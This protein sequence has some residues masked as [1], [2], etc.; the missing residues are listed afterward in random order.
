M[1]YKVIT[2]ILGTVVFGA[3]ADFCGEYDEM[4]S[5]YCNLDRVNYLIDV[6]CY[7]GLA[8]EHIAD[9]NDVEKDALQGALEKIIVAE[10]AKLLSLTQERIL[11]VGHIIA[12]AAI[13]VGAVGCT[14]GIFKSCVQFANSHGASNFENAYEKQTQSA[15]KLAEAVNSRIDCPLVQQVKLEREYDIKRDVFTALKDISHDIS[16]EAWLSGW[17]WLGTAIG[18][19]LTN[20]VGVSV[21]V[22]ANYM[23]WQN[24][25]IKHNLNKFNASLALLNATE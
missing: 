22:Y 6:A 11:K 15:V 1:N 21:E 10:Q 23:L 2:L 14:Y 8:P 24:E 20:S 16:A 7:E 17:K 5:G 3:H 19:V 4:R 18:S 13:V 12:V 9:L 25:E